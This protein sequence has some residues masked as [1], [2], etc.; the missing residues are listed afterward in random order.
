MDA[1]TEAEPELP[2]GVALA[3]GIAVNPQRG[4]KR[5]LSIERIVD[6]AVELADAGGLGAVS[7]SA[8]ATS[9]GFT[10]MSLYRYVTAKDDLV[11]L[12]Q[13]AAHGIPPETVLEADGWREGLRRWN[14]AQVDVYRRHPW[15]LDIPIVGLPVTPASM[16][17]LDTAFTVLRDS[18]LDVE[19]MLDI[20]LAVMAQSRFQGLVERGYD[21]AAAAAG[22]TP[23]QLDAAAATTLMSRITPEAYPELSRAIAAGL[24]GPGPDDPFEFGLELILDGVERLRERDPASRKPP[25]SPPAD[26]DEVL[27]DRKVRE[28]QKAVR[29]AEKQ[30]R[31]ARK[32]EREA[33]TAARE[34]LA[35]G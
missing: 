23:D 19:E 13:E 18:G 30:L 33:R 34:R 15:V 21:D 6:A 3:W 2:R 17:W 4:P 1:M 29:E 7:M 28:A 8:V 32:R 16:A 11:L 20:C 10:T 25:P 35:R 26:P 31:E 5:E 12:M 27:H 24:F 9:L 22:V 14:A